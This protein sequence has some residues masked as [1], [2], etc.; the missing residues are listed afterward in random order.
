[1]PDSAMI[2]LSNAKAATAATARK[3]FKSTPQM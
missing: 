1:M 2:P 3:R